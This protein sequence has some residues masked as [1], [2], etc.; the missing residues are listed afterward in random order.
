[1]DAKNAENGCSNIQES[2][3][4][5]LRDSQALQISQLVQAIS[6]QTRT[7]A[8]LTNA[9][10]QLIVT[11]QQLVAIFVDQFG[12]DSQTGQADTEL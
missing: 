6:A 7:V 1:M 8:S 10:D 3:E 2:Q 9:I 11:N 12:D 5:S 4:I